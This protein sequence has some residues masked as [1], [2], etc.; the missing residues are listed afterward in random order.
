[1][2][3]VFSELNQVPNSCRN[4]TINHIFADNH[5][6]ELYRCTHR[7]RKVEEK[8]V[9][10]MLTCQEESRGYFIYQC[11]NCGEEKLIHFGCNSRICSY[12]G[13]HYADK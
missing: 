3:E 2:E 7:I 1:M 8:E 4:L 9:Q 5:N 11:P 6:W 12:C 10:K 13:K